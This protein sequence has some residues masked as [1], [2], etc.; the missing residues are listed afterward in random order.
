MIVDHSEF[1]AVA[2]REAAIAVGALF[3]GTSRLRVCDPDNVKFDK[4]SEIG[5]RRLLA[6]R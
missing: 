6:R 3:E 4:H 1:R 5:T 2:A